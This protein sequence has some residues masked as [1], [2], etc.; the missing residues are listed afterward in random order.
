MYCKEY[1]CIIDGY[2]RESWQHSPVSSSGQSL[3][4]AQQLTP[5]PLMLFYWLWW[6]QVTSPTLTT[7]Q[8][9]SMTSRLYRFLSSSNTE[10]DHCQ[11]CQN[12]HITNIR[13]LALEVVKYFCKMFHLLDLRS[14]SIWYQLKFID[15][16]QCF[17]FQINILYLFQI[18]IVD[19]HQV[20][21]GEGL[22]VL[23]P[24]LKRRKSSGKVQLRDLCPCSRKIIH[25]RWEKWHAI[26]ISLVCD[27]IISRQ[28][29]HFSTPLFSEETGVLLLQREKLKMNLINISRKPMAADLIF[30]RIAM[31]RKLQHY[32]SSFPLKSHHEDPANA[33]TDQEAP[34]LKEIFKR[35]S[36]AFNKWLELDLSSTE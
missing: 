24:D 9:W 11:D 31:K 4:L 15:L 35:D 23:M 1:R 36:L 28:G 29:S 25:L 18:W 19:L 6:Q 30:I 10:E 27:H 13:Q 20:S 2:E 34:D 21:H 5:A 7:R 16:C 33:Q 8:P 32:F 22:L 17:R 14:F 26:F 12:S 3:V